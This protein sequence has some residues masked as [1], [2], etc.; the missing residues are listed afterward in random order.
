MVYVTSFPAATSR[1]AMRCRSG[2]VADAPPGGRGKTM[3]A[4]GSHEWLANATVGAT[5]MPIGVR[6][7]AVRVNVFVVNLHEGC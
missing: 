2:S 4:F 6:E 5:Q 7:G 3:T 1:S